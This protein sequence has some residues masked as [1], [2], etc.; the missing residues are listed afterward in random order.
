MSKMRFVDCDGCPCL[1]NDYEQGSECN[2]GYETDY[3]LVNE[4]TR[5]YK[6]VSPNCELIE[7]KYNGGIILPKVYAQNPLKLDSRWREMAE[8]NFVLFHGQSE[9]PNP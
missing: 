9:A 5:K 3:I 2:L 1:N 6:H 8:K 7:L 4:E